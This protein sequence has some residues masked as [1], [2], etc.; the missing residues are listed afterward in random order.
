ML[1]FT[2]FKQNR[3]LFAVKN[4]VYTTEFFLSSH[5][6]TFYFSKFFSFYFTS[7]KN[8]SQNTA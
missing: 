2:Y 6:I 8:V 7:E 3:D 4:L 1:S 5:K